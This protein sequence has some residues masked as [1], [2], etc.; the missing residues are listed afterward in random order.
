MPIFREADTAGFMLHKGRKKTESLKQTNSETLTD[1]KLKP[2]DK[3]HSSQSVWRS[4]APTGP[5][6]VLSCFSGLCIQKSLSVKS[7]SQ[8]F[9]SAHLILL[10]C[11]WT[12]STSDK[13]IFPTDKDVLNFFTTLYE[14]CIFMIYNAINGLGRRWDLGF[15]P[16]CMQYTQMPPFCRSQTRYSKCNMNLYS[17][18][19]NKNVWPNRYIVVEHSK[20]QWFPQLVPVES[21]GL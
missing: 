18:W 2:Y 8:R 21:N 19:G 13:C 15:G 10:E 3:I 4:S 9:A 6:T 17:C 7:Q 16:K 12:L 1:S 5:S 20:T 11:S 14:K